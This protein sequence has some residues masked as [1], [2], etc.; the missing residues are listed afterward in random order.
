MGKQAKSS[1]FVYSVGVSLLLV[2]LAISLVTQIRWKNYDQDFTEK[3][4]TAQSEQFKQILQSDLKQTQTE[5]QKLAKPFQAIV[6]IENQKNIF[7]VKNFQTDPQS[8]FARTDED[9]WKSWLKQN[10]EKLLEGTNRSTEVWVSRGPRAVRLIT[11]AINY[12]TSWGIYFAPTH[13]AAGILDA[14][15]KDN[16]DWIVSNSSGE[17]ILHSTTDYIGQSLKSHNLW[18]Q[19]SEVNSP[20]QFFARPMALV[21]K[22]SGIDLTLTIV[23]KIVLPWWQN[24]AWVIAILCLVLIACS[25]LWYFDIESEKKKVTSLNLPD[26]KNIKAPVIDENKTTE[27]MSLKMASSLAEE[28]RVPLT[29]I[30]GHAQFL[31]RNAGLNEVDKKHLDLMQLEARQ[32]RDL[33]DKLFIFAG[34]KKGEK[35]ANR[36]GLA[37]SQA[38]LELEDELQKKQIKI[39]RDLEDHAEIDFDL[40]AVTKALKNILQNS[41]EALDKVMNKEI[42]LSLVQQ[43][44]ELILKI[45]DSGEGMDVEILEKAASPFFTTRTRDHH[46]G[47]GLALVASVA[48]DHKAKLNILSEPGKGTEIILIFKAPEKTVVE[49]QKPILVSPPDLDLEELLSPVSE[50]LDAIAK[51]EF[52]I[53]SE[54][55]FIEETAEDFLK[56]PPQQIPAKKTSRSEQFATHIPQPGTRAP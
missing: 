48:K 42:R 10:Q 6:N 31:E 9:F 53:A 43:E 36:L 52:S 45:A 56:L 12:G 20:R 22:I 44:Q 46:L 35:S 3:M 37:V 13:W 25:I 30:F 55:F 51:I 54:Q 33:L 4:L 34:E 32:I 40:V 15:R 2:I 24:F 21:S 47:L 23:P 50:Q 16:A 41:I 5:N 26:L 7:S 14:F 11:I 19:I 39:I 17:I 29:A 28:L 8:E 18:A 49:T 27:A 38:L 1:L